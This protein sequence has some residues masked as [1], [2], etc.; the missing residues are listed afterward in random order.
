MASSSRS[1]RS[2]S[3]Q[4]LPAADY[5]A[6]AGRLSSALAISLALG[7]VG[8]DRRLVTGKLD[9]RRLAIALVGVHRV[10]VFAQQPGNPVAVQRNRAATLLV[11]SRLH[12]GQD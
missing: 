11:Q 3:C 7:Q 10:V 8:D 5:S 9:T 2:P 12:D 6:G 4:K 1:R